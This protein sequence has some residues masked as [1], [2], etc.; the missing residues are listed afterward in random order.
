[1]G[2]EFRRGGKDSVWGTEHARESVGLMVA[3]TR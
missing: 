3:K 1:M 2:E